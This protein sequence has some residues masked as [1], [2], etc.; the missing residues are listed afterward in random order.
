MILYQLIWYL[1]Q[2][3]L[4]P[5]GHMQVCQ[6]PF[7]SHSTHCGEYALTIEQ[8]LLK[9]T[10]HNLPIR[11]DYFPQAFFDIRDE[12]TYIIDQLPSYLTQQSPN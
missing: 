5:Q 6:L 12:F 10:F 11:H 9:N 7:N 8:S 1:F 3:V 2:R 4:Q